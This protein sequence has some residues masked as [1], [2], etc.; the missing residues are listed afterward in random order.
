MGIESLE[1][2]LLGQN[3]VQMTSFSLKLS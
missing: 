2:S 3:T 1:N